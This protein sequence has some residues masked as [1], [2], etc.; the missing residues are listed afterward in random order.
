SPS[1]RIP[2]MFKAHAK[3]IANFSFKYPEPMAGAK[4]SSLL[5][6]PKLIIE[7][8]EILKMSNRSIGRAIISRPSSGNYLYYLNQTICQDGNKKWH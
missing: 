4:V 5:P 3:T 8:P 2:A 6:M 1:N 7:A